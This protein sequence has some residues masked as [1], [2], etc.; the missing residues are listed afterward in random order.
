[1]SVLSTV[2]GRGTRASQP[3]VT[4]VPA[5]SL[6]YVTDENV[7]ERNSGSAWEDFSDVSGGGPGGGD[8]S[9]TAAY[10]SRPAAGNDGDLFLPNNGFYLERDTGAA[11]VPWGPIHPLTAPI[12]GD[13]AILE[14]VQ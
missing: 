13:F 14:Q 8:S 7:T 4:D 3:A 2:I 10:G 6:Y 9:Y 1:M 11:W 5:G 12:S